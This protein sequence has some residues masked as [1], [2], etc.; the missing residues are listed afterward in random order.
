ML[1]LDH[2]ADR[3]PDPLQPGKFSSSKITE[4]HNRPMRHGNCIGRDT[5]NIDKRVIWLSEQ[6]TGDYLGLPAAVGR[7][8]SPLES[9]FP[10]HGVFKVFKYLSWSR[11]AG[12]TVNIQCY[13]SDKIQLIQD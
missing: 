13:L 8:L 12:S 2:F 4:R 3:D 5:T 6:I 9:S 7:Y 11:V 10:L 1:G